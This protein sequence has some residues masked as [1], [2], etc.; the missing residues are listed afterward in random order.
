MKIALST[1]PQSTGMFEWSRMSS[2]RASFP[3][4]VTS[5]ES[6]FVASVTASFAL[7]SKLAGHTSKY[8]S[9]VADNWRKRQLLCS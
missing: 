7:S 6:L 2:G 1:F 4:M 9:D 3:P 8:V 5:V